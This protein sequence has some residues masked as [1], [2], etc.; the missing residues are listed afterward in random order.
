MRGDYYSYYSAPRNL[1]NTAALACGVI[2]IVSGA[3]MMGLPLGALA[4]VFVILGRKDDKLPMPPQAKW[5]L[6]AGIAG[7]V[8]TIVTL[9]AA[10]VLMVRNP[11]MFEPADPFVPG[12]I[13]EITGDTV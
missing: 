8:I 5:G 10:V 3:S 7:I 6:I 2:S 11:S 13:Q 1:F 4:I 9:V 12:N